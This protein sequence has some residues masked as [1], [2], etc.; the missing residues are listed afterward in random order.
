[1]K[2]PNPIILSENTPFYCRNSQEIQCHV[3][4]FGQNFHKIDTPETSHIKAAC[5]S[6]NIS[7]PGTDEHSKILIRIFKNRDKLNFSSFVCRFVGSLFKIDANFSTK[8]IIKCIKI[9]YYCLN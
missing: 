8:I 2:N 7:I 1:M 5:M 4:I 6:D 3:I 9:Y